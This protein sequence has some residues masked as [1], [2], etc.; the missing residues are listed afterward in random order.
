MPEAPW[1]EKDRLEYACYFSS[2]LAALSLSVGGVVALG[3]LVLHPVSSSA[4]LEPSGAGCPE[5]RAGVGVGSE[6]P[7]GREARRVGLGLPLP[8]GP[9]D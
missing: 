1:L 6:N 4:G 3:L 5:G 2:L 9:S 7:R 8:G